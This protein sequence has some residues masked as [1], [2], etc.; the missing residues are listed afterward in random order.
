MGPPRKLS[1]DDLARAR[2]LLADG[3]SGRSV[4]REL[5]VDHRGLARHLDRAA[6]AAGS[7]ARTQSATEVDSAVSCGRRAFLE[8]SA[9]R[10]EAAM[11]GADPME[12]A[13]L[14]GEA[15]S[16]W[17]E[18]AVLDRL[19]NAATQPAGDSELAKR[20]RARL[21]ALARPLARTTP[22]TSS[23]TIEE[24]GERAVTSGR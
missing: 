9:E 8:R 10:L 11:L 14:T 5:R 17:S 2:Q 3:R 18:L 16:V 22:P 20:V 15:R 24:S 4:A 19:D 23:S 7:G 21:E 6:R 13:R 12:L 1:R